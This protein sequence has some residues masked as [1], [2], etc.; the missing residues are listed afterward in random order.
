[1]EKQNS[2]QKRAPWSPFT[3]LCAK[4]QRGEGTYSRPHG[5][6]VAELRMKLHLPSP[7]AGNLL[8]KLFTKTANLSG[9]GIPY[10]QGQPRGK[11][12]RR[13]PGAPDLVMFDICPHFWN[14]QGTCEHL[15]RLLRRQNPAP[16]LWEP[17][18]GHLASGA[19]GRT[20]PAKLTRRRVCVCVCVCVCV[21]ARARITQ[22]AVSVR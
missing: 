19:W 12:P 1:M 14:L 5:K 13:P 4:A 17:G 21:R 3:G 18:R 7:T 10:P 22:Q 9:R 20:A 8:S 2:R 16:D 15:E 11:S 6:P